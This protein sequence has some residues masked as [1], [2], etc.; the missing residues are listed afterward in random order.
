[1]FLWEKVNKSCNSCHLKVMY[2][3]DDLLV[4]VSVFRGVW[5]VIKKSYIQGGPLI[6]LIQ[7]S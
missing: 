1:M 5:Q 7:I 3:G 4:N 2:L 6:V